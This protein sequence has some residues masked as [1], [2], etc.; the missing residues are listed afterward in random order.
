MSTL[1]NEIRMLS[2]LMDQEV[3]GYRL[4]IEALDQE[5]ECL[6]NGDIDSLLEVV[7]GI[8]SHT[9]ALRRLQA[10]IEA[11]L[12]AAFEALGVDAEKQTFSRLTDDLPPE[13]RLKMKSFHRT[14]NELRER[15]RLTNERNK[16][17]IREHVA[18]LSD[19]SSLMIRPVVEGPCYPNK[20][21]PR[22]TVSLPYALNRE[23]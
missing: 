9:T 8:E 11:S 3:R 13:H 18:F 4:I 6:K 1:E 2:E 19:L 14:L 20:G 7:K 12:H 15:V 16:R 22:T 10:P 17:F 5:A 21:K 23:V